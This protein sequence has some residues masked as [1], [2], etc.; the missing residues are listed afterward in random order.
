M[1]YKAS[2]GDIMKMFEDE[3]SISIHIRKQLNNEYIVRLTAESGATKLFI[4][5]NWENLFKD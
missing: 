5:D 1:V 4:T 2:N 3:D